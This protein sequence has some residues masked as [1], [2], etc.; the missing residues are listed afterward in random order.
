ME[1]VEKIKNV[2]EKENIKYN[3]DELKKVIEYALEKYK[4]KKV[5]EDNAIDFVVEVASEVATLR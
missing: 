4:D 5:L 3:E 1:Y 2:L